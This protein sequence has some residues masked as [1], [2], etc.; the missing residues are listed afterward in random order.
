MKTQHS[1]ESVFRKLR[2]S[3]GVYTES[4]N[5]PRARH[6]LYEICIRQSAVSVQAMHTHKAADTK[7]GSYGY[8]N[9]P[10]IVIIHSVPD[11]VFF[12]VS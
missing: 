3:S 5:G 12:V 1:S 8:S 9:K 4:V 2:I 7:T 11:H 6:M 10:I